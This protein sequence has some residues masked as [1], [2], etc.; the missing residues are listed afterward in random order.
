MMRYSTC[1]SRYAN[2]AYIFRSRRRHPP[3]I[4]ILFLVARLYLRVANPTAFQLQIHL[5][6]RRKITLEPEQRDVLIILSPQRKGENANARN[7]ERAKNHI[8]RGDENEFAFGP[9]VF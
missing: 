2:N 3:Q 5:R 8:C 4:F 7:R 6:R 9:A 1:L